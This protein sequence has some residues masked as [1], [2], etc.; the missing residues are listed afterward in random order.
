METNRKLEIAYDLARAYGEVPYRASNGGNLRI[1][2][3]NYIGY[4]T[5]LNEDPSF[6]E[7]AEVISEYKEQD[8]DDI[9][10]EIRQEYF[11]S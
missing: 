9:N 6:E 4:A 2:Y 8:T 10:Y 5:S 3:D 1:I 7:F 11:N